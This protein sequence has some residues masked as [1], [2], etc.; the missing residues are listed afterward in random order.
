MKC[1]IDVR[2]LLVYCADYKCSHSIR[3]DATTC[4]RWG[5]DVRLS[6]IEPQFVCTACGTRGAEIR[7]HFDWEK[8]T[9]GDTPPT[10]R[11]G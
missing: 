3:L 10:D 11:S 2:G 1:S 4:D 9:G 5:G 6:D 8:K 7:G